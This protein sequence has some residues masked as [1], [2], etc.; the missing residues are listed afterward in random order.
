L[1]LDRASQAVFVVEDDSSLRSALERLLRI[2]GWSV[3]TFSSAEEFLEHSCNS[4][5]GCLI[6]DIHLGRMSGLELLAILTRTPAA[7]PVILTTGFDGGI[8]E[9]EAIRLGAFAFFRKPFD[10]SA[11][12]ACVERGMNWKPSQ[13]PDQPTKAT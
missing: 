12:L 2:A 5:R 13:V 6:A 3:R 7:M 10:S 9:A 4:V 8:T 1:E 11:L